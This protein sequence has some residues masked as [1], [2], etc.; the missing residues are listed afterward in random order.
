MYIPVNPVVFY[1]KVG[2][3]G[4]RFYRHIFEMRKN[5]DESS[6]SFTMYL[7]IL[8]AEISEKISTY[9]NANTEAHTLAGSRAR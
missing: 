9:N 2:L 1:I 4:S 5:A 6:L 7:F 3:K 8:W